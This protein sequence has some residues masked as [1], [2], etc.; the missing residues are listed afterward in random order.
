M[1]YVFRALNEEDINNV[2]IDNGMLKPKDTLRGIKTLKDVFR[3]VNTHLLYGSSKQT[4]WISI[5]KDFKIAAEKY[6]L[7]KKGLADKRAPI[8]VIKNHSKSSMVDDKGNDAFENKTIEQ[9]TNPAYMQFF[10]DFELNYISKIV[11]DFSN[12]EFSKKLARAGYV[13]NSENKRCISNTMA[14]NYAANSK[15]MLVYKNIPREDIVKVL[16]PLEV[17]IIYGSGYWNGKINNEWKKSLESN[18]FRGIMLEKLIS[19]GDQIQY[20]DFVS[21]EN[22]DSYDAVYGDEN[23]KKIFNTNNVEIGKVVSEYKEARGRVLLDIV[24]EL[25][26]PEEKSEGLL[27]GPDICRS[28]NNDYIEPIYESINLVK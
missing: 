23:G 16:S 11:L 6:S 7:A 27:W 5:T 14:Y 10:H 8:A 26:E 18:T 22:L 28:L 19:K 15:E 12:K 2:N 13:L 17:D 20:R 25:V 4:C 3:K 9:L 21:K 24:N 1:S